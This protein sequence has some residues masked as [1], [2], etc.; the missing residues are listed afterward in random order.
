MDKE[1]SQLLELKYGK[2]YVEAVSFTLLREGGKSNNPKDKGGLTNF[3][4]TKP[5]LTEYLGRPA[6]NED[7]EA[8]DA[9][10]AI[11]AYYALVWKKFRLGD[12][13]PAVA[14][15]L[16]DWFVT[17]GGA[18]EQIQR[19]L[20]LKADGVFGPKTITA[21]KSVTQGLTPEG[22]V[23]QICRL[24]QL[25]YVRLCKNDPSQLAFLAGWINRTHLA[26]DIYY[27][28]AR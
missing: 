1:T 10:T 6:R 2:A 28:R 19:W 12:L 8:L 16:F 3:G 18:D 17:S 5:F 27:A 7:I 15:C 9:F 26:E 23:L 4:I 21:I 22:V 11:D 13:H 24:R 14:G 25:Y 20:N